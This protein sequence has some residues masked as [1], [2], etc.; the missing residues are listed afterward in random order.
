MQRRFFIVL[1]ILTCIAAV[2]AQERYLR[3]VDDAAKDPSFLAFR[4]KLIAAIDRRD[5]A[6]V[7]GILDPKV[8]LNFGGDYGVSAFKKAWKPNNRNSE[9]WTVFGTIM[10]NGGAFVHKKGEVPLFYAPYTFS[11]FPE[12][13]DSFEHYAI[14]GNNVNLRESP[15]MNG[16]VVSQLSYNIV[17]V[18][19]SDA[20]KSE[21]LK[22]TTLGGKSGFVKAE[23]VRSPIDFRAGF[24]KRR[25]VWKMV[26]LLSGD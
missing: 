11:S 18:A 2:S 4:T 3:P 8:Q 7:I 10:K 6:Y 12:D 16:K 1:F 17:K 21:W 15:S 9:F 24:E 13:L 26:T 23:F 14:F 5:A 22:V 19:P 25:G 20:E